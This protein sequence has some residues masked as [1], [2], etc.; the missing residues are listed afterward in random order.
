MDAIPNELAQAAR[1][2]RER[3]AEFSRTTA[4]AG[5]GRGQ[6]DLQSAMAG[7]ARQAIFA[8][9]LTAAMHARL[10]ELKGVAK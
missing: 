4:V 5:A 10:E 3:L 9:A 2:A 8:D 7:A 6:P 1:D